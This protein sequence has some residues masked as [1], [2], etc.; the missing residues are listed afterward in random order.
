MIMLLRSADLY[1]QCGWSVLGV[2]W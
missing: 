2:S 1:H